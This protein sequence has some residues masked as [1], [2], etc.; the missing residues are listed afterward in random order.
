[1]PGGTEESH[2]KAHEDSQSPSQDLNTEPH[3]LKAGVPA[4]Q[5]QCSVSIFLHYNSITLYS[6]T[7]DLLEKRH[8]FAVRAG[9]F[10]EDILLTFAWPG[11]NVGA[12]QTLA[13]GD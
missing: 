9:C 3:E 7:S 11:Y 1:L 8:G 6:L 5:L 10:T 13:L 12:W 4:D 2:E